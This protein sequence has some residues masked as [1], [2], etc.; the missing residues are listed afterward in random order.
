M[1]TGIDERDWIEVFVSALVVD[2]AG[3]PS[4][5]LETE[6][7]ARMSVC[8]GVAEAP[9]IAAG[10]DGALLERPCA[11]DLMVSMIACLRG[12]VERVDIGGSPGALRAALHLYLDGRALALDARPSD[13]LALAL[14][15]QAPIRVAASLVEPLA[16]TPARVGAHDAGAA[17]KWKM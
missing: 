14:R 5:I 11:H 4:A 13:A 6:D 3:A 1:T 7:G 9:A 12:E 16:V 8:I 17:P 15:T 2:L 10:L